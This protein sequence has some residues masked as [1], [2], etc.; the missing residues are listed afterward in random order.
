MVLGHRKEKDAGLKHRPH[1]VTMVFVGTCFIWFGWLCFNGGSTLNATV[2]AMYAMF[3]TNIAASTGILGWVVTD[4]CRKGKFS[5]VSACEGAIAGLVGITPA[6]GYVP[7]WAAAL[8][9]LV[10]AIVCASLED[11]NSWTR[12]D[13]SL[14]VFKLHGIGGLV[15][16][17]L[18]GIFAT[19]SG[20]VC[21]LRQEG[22]LPI[23]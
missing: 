23:Y 9:G 20:K 8:I 6:A 5:T 7:I 16:S 21:P 17:F 14:D 18:T 3:N 12:I 1:N 4:Y 19:A 11:L 22:V 15:G 2:R 10:T 13:E